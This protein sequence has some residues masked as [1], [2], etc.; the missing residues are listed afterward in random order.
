MEGKKQTTL[1]R[2]Q[3]LKEQAENKKTSGNEF[4]ILDVN[5][6]LDLAERGIEVLTSNEE[7]IAQPNGIR[8]TIEQ[9]G[10][11]E[12]HDTKAAFAIVLDE[13]EN[14]LI[15]FRLKNC[16]KLDKFIMYLAIRRYIEELAKNNHYDKLYEKAI[17]LGMIKTEIDLSEA[18]TEGGE[19]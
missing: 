8:V 14:P 18:S 2:L 17:E 13:D 5:F 9:D 15:H 3:R 7:P 6:A 11:R 19:A 16:K 4:M 12:I 10:E 1:E